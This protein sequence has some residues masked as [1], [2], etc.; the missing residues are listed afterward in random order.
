MRVTYLFLLVIVAISSS[1]CGK[2]PSSISSSST[3]A[4]VSVRSNQTISGY[5]DSKIDYY[6]PSNATTAIV[7]LHGGGGKK[8]PMAADLD[9]KSD[10]TDTNFTLSSTGQAWLLSEKV[11]AVFPQGL[12][13]S[14][15]SAWTW[16]NYVMVSGQSDVAFLQA[17][18]ATIKSDPTLPHITKIYLVGH[19]NG[20]MMANRMWCE[21]PTT[22]DGYGALAG[23]PSVHLDPLTGNHPCAP[24]TIKP[25]IGIIGNQDRVL[26][27]GGNM[28]AS[29]WTINPLMYV[30]HPPTW[31]D[32]T[33]QIMND[34]LFHATRVSLNCGG[35][36]NSP[37]I[38]GQLTT[39]SDCNDTLKLIVVS[40]SGGVGGDHCL[41]R[42][43]GTCTTT[44]N[45][46]SGLDYK[47]TLWSF[48]KNF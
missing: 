21:S 36:L 30:G 39:Y 2:T 32:T 38:S 42:T 19:S 41:A 27:T 4:T 37:L 7:F 44:L 29:T 48:L 24:S 8:E 15:Y 31:A 33:P 3:S 14:S 9:I 11:M 46:N 13:L 47:T 34:K 12:T 35:S 25:Y 17:L 23:P 43:S 6:I 5:P 28:A 1:G 10:T 26:E 16:D 40:Q 18:A 20:G 45:G 22:F